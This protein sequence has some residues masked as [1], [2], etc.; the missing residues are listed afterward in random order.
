M[1]REKISAIQHLVFVF[2][3]MVALVGALIATLDF[4][5]TVRSSPLVIG[6]PTL[7]LVIVLLFKEVKGSLPLVL[8]IRRDERPE[9]SFGKSRYPD[10]GSEV[11]HESRAFAWLGFLALGVLFVGFLVGALVFMVLFLRLQGKESWIVILT[12]ALVS[13]VFYVGAVH[14][15][16]MSL[17][18]GYFPV[19]SLY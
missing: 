4:S 11:V 16:G 19:F 7:L 18:R 5:P 6:I 14:L 10:G 8:N 1:C 2:L 15:L 13:V 3:V 9:T 17:Y 12:T